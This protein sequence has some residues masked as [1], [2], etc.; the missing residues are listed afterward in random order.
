MTK[1]EI[2][3]NDVVVP[4]VGEAS[5]ELRIVKWLKKVG[6]YVGEGENLFEL[7]IEKSVLEVESVYSGTLS[8]ILVEE[9]GSVEPL[10][11]VCRIKS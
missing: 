5:S 3:V 11:V 6:D 8:E 7:D 10:Q 4:Q 9:G 2:M 1:E